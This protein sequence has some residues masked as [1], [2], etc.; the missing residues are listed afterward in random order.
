GTSVERGLAGAAAKPPRFQRARS[1]RP[2]PQA[3]ARAGRSLTQG[4]SGDG[5]VCFGQ[6]H[7]LVGVPTPQ[8]FLRSRREPQRLRVQRLLEDRARVACIAKAFS[9]FNAT[10]DTTQLLSGGRSHAVRVLLREQLGNRDQL[11]GRVV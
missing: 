3:R 8:R 2:P 5:E 10:E 11:V 7:Q 9:A 4:S 6:T 1:R